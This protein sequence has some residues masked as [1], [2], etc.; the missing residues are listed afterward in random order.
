MS[1]VILGEPIAAP[2]LGEPC[3]I[4]PLGE[5][6]VPIFCLKHPAF[7]DDDPPGDFRNAAAVALGEDG[8]AR[9]LKDAGS[10]AT[11]GVAA[12][13][14]T[15]SDGVKIGVG[16]GEL[17]IAPIPLCGLTITEGVGKRA[18]DSV[19]GDLCDGEAQGEFGAPS[20]QCELI[21]W[22]NCRGEF[23]IAKPLKR[24]DLFE[25]FDPPGVSTVPGDPGAATILGELGIEANT[26]RACG[27]AAA[28]AAAAA[29]AEVTVEPSL[30]D[31]APLGT[32]AAG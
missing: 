11:A 16:L 20:T 10:A 22:A 5:A 6:G 21:G 8:P 14:I 3:F 7:F 24:A 19:V 15:P 2:A 9:T 27:C 23:G 12:T 4:F 30:V 26:L 13:V 25:A 28:A 18:I 17:V 32:A 29:L 1:Y 31:G